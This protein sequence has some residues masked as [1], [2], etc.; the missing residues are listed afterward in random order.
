M[1][2]KNTKMKLSILERG[3]VPVRNLNQSLFN[4]DVM[5]LSNSNFFLKPQPSISSKNRNLDLRLFTLIILNSGNQFFG[6][7]LEIIYFQLTPGKRQ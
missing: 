5:P 7:V 4:Q 2:S 1:D 3:N 6:L